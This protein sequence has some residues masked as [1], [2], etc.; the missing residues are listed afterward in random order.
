MQ[1]KIASTIMNSNANLAILV[2][3]NALVQEDALVQEFVESVLEFRRPVSYYCA[4]VAGPAVRT[5]L[6]GRF[7]VVSQRSVCLLRKSA[8]KTRLAIAGRRWAPAAVKVSSAG[9]IA[10]R[11][12]GGASPPIPCIS[13]CP[14]R[15]GAPTAAG[16]LGL[17]LRVGRNF[18]RTC[19]GRRA[20][21]RVPDLCLPPGPPFSSPLRPTA[22]TCPAWADVGLSNEMM[23][24][25]PSC[26]ASPTE[27]GPCETCCPGNALG[28]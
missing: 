10:S 3:F 18:V 15:A 12:I 11:P 25:L 23:P 22:E 17:G 1:P 5:P 4:T 7:R 24:S 16:V 13:G 2:Y 9:P 14:T 20:G 28:H 26:Q 27:P 21:E 6:N 8:Q 19:G